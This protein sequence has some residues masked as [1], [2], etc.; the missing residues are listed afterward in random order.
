MIACVALFDPVTGIT[1]SMPRP[2]R[3]HHIL[4]ALPIE[5]PH[6][7]LVQGFM[8]DGIGGFI[9]RE[10]ATRY[11]KANGIKMIGSVLTSEDLW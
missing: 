3:H 4:H 8:L 2:K 7:R 5:I 6:D 9:D 10:E 11:A 1:Y